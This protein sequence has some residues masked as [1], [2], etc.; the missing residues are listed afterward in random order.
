MSV[1]HRDVGLFNSLFLL[2]MFSGLLLGKGREKFVLRSE[3][4]GSEFRSHWKT[5]NCSCQ[6]YK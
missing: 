1:P 3:I 6:V 5:L 4:T 2:G